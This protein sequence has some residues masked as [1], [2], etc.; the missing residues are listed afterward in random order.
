MF[1]RLWTGKVLHCFD[2]ITVWCMSL[3]WLAMISH[4]SPSVGFTTYIQLDLCSAPD[5]F[6][7]EIL[8]SWESSPRLSPTDYQDVYTYVINRKKYLKIKLEAQHEPACLC[9]VSGAEPQQ[10]MTQ[11]K[12][13]HQ[14]EELRFIPT[15]Y[16]EK[17][18]SLWRASMDLVHKQLGDRNVLFC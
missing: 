7:C 5:C 17:T 2:G 13:H 6:I 15:S 1:H 11:R 10:L 18:L 14:K 9:L 4:S 12:C 8:I 3:L 16:I